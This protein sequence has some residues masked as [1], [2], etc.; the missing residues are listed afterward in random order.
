[1]R[2]LC[3]SA[4]LLIFAGLAAHPA[5][6]E[7]FTT[8]RDDSLRAA[9][10][11]RYWLSPIYVTA[12]RAERPM[13]RVPYAINTVGQ[14]EIQ[15]A[16]SGLSLDETM[17]TIPGV[18]VANR[19]NFSRGDRI[20]M[21]G[22]GS[23]TQYGV[24]GLRIVLDHIPMT[25]V[26]GQSRLYN[27]D[28]TSAGKI[29]VLRGPCSALYGNAAGGLLDVQT[30]PAARQSFLAR[31]RYVAGSHGYQ[32]GQL[33]LSGKFGRHAYVVNAN[34]VKVDGY[35]EHSSAAYTRINAVGR[36]TLSS[37][38][39]LTSVI[40]YYDAPYQLNPSGLAKAD[41][42]DAPTV[43]RAYVKK[44]GSGATRTQAQGGLTMKY[45]DGERSQFEA[46]AYGVSYTSTYALPGVIADYE[47]LAGG[48]RT[49]Y[50]RRLQAAGLPL[51]LTAGVDFEVKSGSR[52]DYRSLGLPDDQLDPDDKSRIYDL[53]ERDTLRVDQDDQFLGVGSFVGL[54]GTLGEGWQLTLGGRY[55]HY[56]FETDDDFLRD[57]SDDSG[58]RSM[59]R[60][61]P[62]AGLVWRPRELMKVYGHFSTA[63]QTPTI[64]E[65]VTQPT[66]EAGF[67]EDLDPEIMRSYEIGLR[68][69]LSG[70][71]ARGRGLEYDLA[72]YLLTVEDMLIPYQV[73]DPERESTFYR[74]AGEAAN[75]GADLG[76]TWHLRDNLRAKLAYSYMDFTF[77]DF[78]AE[79]GSGDDVERVQLKGNEVPGVPPQQFFAG[80][81][82]EHPVGAYS[83]LEMRWVDDYFANDFN[84]PPPGSDKPVGDYVNDAHKVVDL[85]VG[86]ERRFSELRADCFLGVDNLFDE[87]YSG[88][89]VPNEAR[90]RFF[91][92]APERTWY[93]GV[94]VAL[95]ER[96]S[97]E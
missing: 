26:D 91:E 37:R 54:E 63:F 88:S 67:N 71:G 13:L 77:E 52:E 89:I 69:M 38:Y 87:R 65:L 1:M 50:D 20:M 86:F 2:R 41:A 55:D 59:E 96:A 79:V 11:V 60:F 10:Q 3:L 90:D 97:G 45:R 6:G 83:S 47:E 8:P 23:R 31:P 95:P 85:R 53:I 17:R 94:S 14:Q 49:V 74:N 70:A 16:A 75:R 33:M 56:R 72:L 29:E 22:I 43:T 58:E 7:D 18:T 32:R 93:A 19:H 28:L 66:G 76:L 68:G 40:N 61:S 21:R 44:M 64:E 48:L 25:T 46:T 92:P 34:T 39:E 82:Y 4:C 78:V 36:H 62:K 84:G 35:R 42:S 15:R 73:D 12:T 24:R 81:S 57:E 51:R 80:L 27:L 5:R 9:H 30:Q